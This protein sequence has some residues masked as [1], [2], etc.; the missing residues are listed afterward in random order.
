MRTAY[1]TAS[2]AALQ[3]RFSEWL[4]WELDVNPTQ[5]GM[6]KHCRLSYRW[7]VIVG[8]YLQTS[9]TE[10]LFT[11][12]FKAVAG[13]STNLWCAE[14]LAILQELS[15]ILPAHEQSQPSSLLSV[16]QGILC[17]VRYLFPSLALVC[18]DTHVVTARL[19]V[20]PWLLTL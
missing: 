20:A 9:S 8:D 14:F 3:V 18:C 15:L 1:G 11:T 13:R 17:T 19:A 7:N 16:L 4:S 10:E 12:L 2:S 6:N 5:D